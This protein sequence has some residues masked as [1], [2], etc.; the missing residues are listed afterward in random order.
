VKRIVLVV[1]L[2][3][4]VAGCAGATG[5]GSGSSAQPVPV[6]TRPAWETSTSPPPA[7]L[8]T[9]S[10]STPLTI[11]S[12][13]WSDISETGGVG[14]CGDTPPFDLMK[15][16]A[17]AQVVQ[18]DTVALVLALTPSKPIELSLGGHTMTLPAAARSE[19]Q[20]SGQ[21]ILEVFATFPQGDV[22]Y[23]IRITSGSG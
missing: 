20:V 23:G 5:A 11:G 18:G 4:V 9:S 17:T 15:S 12:Y 2:V 22:S 16:L 3:L 10:G 7:F 8:E 13:C 19:W 6:S 14:A 21:G 1:S